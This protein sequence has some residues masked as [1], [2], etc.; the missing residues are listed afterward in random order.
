MTQWGYARVSTV[1]QDAALQ[2]DALL[3]AGVDRAHIV[4]DHASG[5][6]SRD[7]A[8]MNCWDGWKTAMF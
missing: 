6:K 3:A 8:S 7:L 4:V 1:D 2:L 5:T